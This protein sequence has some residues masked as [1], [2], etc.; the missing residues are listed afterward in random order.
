M[1]TNQHSQAP[2]AT[3]Y[4][5]VEIAVEVYEP[6]DID[7]VARGIVAQLREDG[8]SVWRVI[9]ITSISQLRLTLAGGRALTE[10][11]VDALGSGLAHWAA[12]SE[13]VSWL[14]LIPLCDQCVARELLD[15][16]PD[17]L[18]LLEE[19]FGLRRSV[20]LEGMD[21][22]ASLDAGLVLQ[23]ELTERLKK[24]IRDGWQIEGRV[25]RDWGE[26]VR[27]LGAA[28]VTASE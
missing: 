22:L 15:A 10:S 1:D 9:Q 18:A 25:E 8:Q 16:E 17:E 3:V 4:P 26:L 24:L 28:A 23:P 5:Y 12:E 27:S 21:G 6:T 11:Q 14:E 13:L 2:E 7:A 20:R 19:H